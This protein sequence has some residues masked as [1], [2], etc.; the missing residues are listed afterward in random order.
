MALRHDLGQM[1]HRL[2]A[3][4]QAGVETRLRSLFEKGEGVA[5]RSLE[6]I[7]GRLE[8]IESYIEKPRPSAP[9]APR[10]ARRASARKR[11]K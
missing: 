2:V 8:A 5:G 9:P 1:V 3:E 11:K 10:G 7:Q 4:A 6:V